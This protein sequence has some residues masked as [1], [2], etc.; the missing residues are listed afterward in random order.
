MEKAQRNTC[1]CSSFHWLLNY[2]YLILNSAFRNVNSLRN[3]HYIWNLWAECKNSNV[4]YFANIQCFTYSCHLAPPWNSTPTDGS[5]QGLTLPHYMYMN[6]LH[7][8]TYPL[9]PY[10]YFSRASTLNHF[11]FITATVKV[12]SLVFEET[13]RLRWVST[14]H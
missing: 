7:V 3:L 5:L 14:W 9:L 10:T 11:I 6:Y 2:L 4:K 13:M 1:T 8:T 12:M